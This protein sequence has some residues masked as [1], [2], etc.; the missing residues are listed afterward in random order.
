MASKKK[1]STEQGSPTSSLVE[2]EEKIMF[3]QRAIEE[4]NDVVLKQQNEL[5]R[6]GREIES[7]RSVTHGLVE[8]GTGE[9]LPHEK[10]PHY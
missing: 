10:P 6:L 3:Q 5:E 8:R 1:P 4:L 7:L 9:D 2:L